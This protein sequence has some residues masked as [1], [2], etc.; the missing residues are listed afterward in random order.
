LEGKKKNS[1]KKNLSVFMKKKEKQRRETHKKKKQNTKTT[2]AG[3]P[4][5]LYI[6]FFFILP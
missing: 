6:F 5:D 2:T 1:L 3:W 4:F